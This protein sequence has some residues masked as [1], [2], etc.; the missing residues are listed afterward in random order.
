MNLQGLK[1]FNIEKY[2]NVREIKIEKEIRVEVN[3]R[4]CVI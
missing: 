1:W 3:D 2:S 4:K